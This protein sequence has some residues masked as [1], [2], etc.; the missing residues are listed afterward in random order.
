[1]AEIGGKLYL[2]G[3]NDAS[4]STSSMYEY[5]PAA[6]QWTEV[7]LVDPPSARFGFGMAASD[8]KIFVHGGDIGG[9]KLL[10]TIEPPSCVHP[11]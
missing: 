6:A 11:P 2:F 7:G 10:R 8:G 3:G 4:G 9:G 5:D 1:M